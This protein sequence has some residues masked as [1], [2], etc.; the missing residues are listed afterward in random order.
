VMVGVLAVL[1]LV[2]CVY[3]FSFSSEV[4]PIGNV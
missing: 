2:S 3:A 1:T 4:T